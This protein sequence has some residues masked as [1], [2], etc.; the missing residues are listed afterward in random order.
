MG[1]SRLAEIAALFARHGGADVPAAVVQNATLPTARAVIGTVANIAVRAA[2][3][4]LAA[5]AVIVLGDV[6]RLAK[7]ATRPRPRSPACCAKLEPY[8]KVA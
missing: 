8:A 6:V 4:G 1:L 7:Q 3:A 2:Q 5:P